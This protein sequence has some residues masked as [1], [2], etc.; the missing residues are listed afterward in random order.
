MSASS[1]RRAAQSL[2]CREY[3]PWSVPVIR[4]GR[5]SV[6]FHTERIKSRCAKLVAIFLARARADDRTR[7]PG[8]EILQAAR[9]FVILGKIFVITAVI[10]LHGRGMRAPGLVDDGGDEETDRKSVV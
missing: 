1:A 5:E 6:L 3:R 2:C 7:E 9:L 8:F 4:R 10:A